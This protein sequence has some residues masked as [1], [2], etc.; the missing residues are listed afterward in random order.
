MGRSK[1]SENKSANFEFRLSVR[2]AFVGD[3]P[4]SIRGV[5]VRE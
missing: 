4:V 5:D 1:R 3:S 2:R